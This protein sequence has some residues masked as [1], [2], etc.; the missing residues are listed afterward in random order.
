MRRRCIHGQDPLSGVAQK[1]LGNV[2][3]I[4][5]RTGPAF[6]WCATG[7]DLYKGWSGCIHKTQV[8][9]VLRATDVRRAGSNAAKTGRV[10]L[11]VRHPTASQAC[12]LRTSAAAERAGSSS[13][14][15]A[16]RPVDKTKIRRSNIG[17]TRC[18]PSR[19]IR[20]PASAPSSHYSV[21]RYDSCNP[22]PQ[23]RGA[24]VLL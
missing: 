6:V 2:Y 11:Q 21:H 1:R 12:V 15:S 7:L 16:P 8:I 4:C 18:H 10:L 3:G 23:Y 19:N 9:D 17:T 5:K 13:A 20:P 22:E 14:L 24:S